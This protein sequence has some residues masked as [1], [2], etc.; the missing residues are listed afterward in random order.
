MVVELNET[1]KVKELFD[2][3]KETQI[4][5]C[6]QKVMGRIFVTDLENPTSAFAY[7]GCFGFVAGE[8]NRELLENLPEDFLLTKSS[9]WIL[10]GELSF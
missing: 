9:T 3:W 10:A 1:S 8:P 5:S 2:G 7:V 4:Y 6:L